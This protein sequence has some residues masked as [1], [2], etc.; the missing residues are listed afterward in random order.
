MGVNVSSVQLE[1]SNEDLLRI[2]TRTGANPSD[3]WLEVTERLNL[4][5]DISGQVERLRS[6]GVHFALDDFGMSYSSL[7]YLQHFPVE[8]IKIDRTFVDPMTEDET[9]QGIVRAI[10]ALAESLSVTVIAEG[11]ETVEQ[12][13][14][15][16][17]LGCVYGQ[18]YLLGR[19]MTGDEC[20]VALSSD[21]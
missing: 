11:V 14:T 20:V 21:R 18:G 16:L 2:I 15:L 13:D 9:Q 12:R 19:P 7:T 17:D 6:A 4:S 3:I 10:L 8:G 1:Q 5:G